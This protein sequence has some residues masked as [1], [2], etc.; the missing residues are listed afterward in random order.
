MQN[1][2]Q[3]DFEYTNDVSKQLEYEDAKLNQC[4]L[5]FKTKQG[6]YDNQKIINSKRFYETNVDD[7][8][9][10]GDSS[11]IINFI[12]SKKQ[13]ED[14]SDNE[15][16]KQNSN[17]GSITKKKHQLSQ[18]D[19]NLILNQSYF[20]DQPKKE[21]GQLEEHFRSTNQ[22]DQGVI[23]E[24]PSDR[25]T[26]QSVLS[27]QKCDVSDTLSRKKKQS[28][29]RADKKHLTTNVNKANNK[30]NNV[31]EYTKSTFKKKIKQDDIDRF[32]QRIKAFFYNKTYSGK[33][34]QLTEKVRLKIGDKSDY[35]DQD[36]RISMHV[37]IIDLIVAQVVWI[38]D[39]LI[40]MNTAMYHDNEF[41]EDRRIIM[42]TFLKEYFFFEVLPIIFENLHSSNIYVSILFHLPLLLKMKG[43][44]IMLD[45]LEFYILQMLDNHSIF[46]LFKL[47]MKMLLFGHILACLKYVVVQLEL[48]YQEQKIWSQ[49]EV[50]YSSQDQITNYLQCMYW[51]FTVMLNVQQPTPSTNLELVFTTFCMILSSIAFGY[52][53]SAIASI[54][55]KLNKNTEDFNKD[56]NILNQYMKRKK[57]EISLKRRANINLK[58]YYQQQLRTNIVEEKAT[59]QKVNSRMLKELLVSSNQKILKYC[60]FLTNLFSESTL[61]QICMS[62][63][64]VYYTPQETIV[65]SELKQSEHY[66]YIIIDGKVKVCEN[67]DRLAQP[68]NQQ[69]YFITQQRLLDK[70]MELQRIKK[71]NQ[72]DNSFQG[73]IYQK[74][75]YFGLLGL[76]LDTQL[77]QKAQSLEYTTIL[78]LSRKE[79]DRIIM[80]NQK[81]REMFMELKDRIL[82]NKDF[83]QLQ[84][85]CQFCNSRQHINQQCIL[86][87]FDRSN[88][89]LHSKNNFSQSQARGNLNQKRKQKYFH[90]LLDQRQIEDNLFELKSNYGMQSTNRIEFTQ[91]EI[92]DE[93]QENSQDQ[94]NLEQNEELFGS[95]EELKILEKSFEENNELDQKQ[96]ESISLDNPNTVSSN[97]KK[98]QSRTSQREKLKQQIKDNLFSKQINYDDSLKIS[99]FN[100]L[101][102]DEAQ[103]T[104]TQQTNQ[105]TTELQ[106]QSAQSLYNLKQNDIS[107]SINQQIQNNQQLSNRVRVKSQLSA[108]DEDTFIIDQIEDDYISKKSIQQMPSYIQHRSYDVYFQDVIHLQQQ[109]LQQQQQHEKTS[110]QNSLFNIQRIPTIDTGPNK[111]QIN[112]SQNHTPSSKQ[113]Y[114]GSNKMIEKQSTL[115]SN[116]QK[117]KNSLKN[118]SSINCQSTSLQPTISVRDLR[119]GNSKKEQIH[120]QLSKM[121]TKISQKSGSIPYKVEQDLKKTTKTNIQNSEI[122]FQDFMESD[123]H[124]RHQNS[125]HLNQ[126]KIIYWY[127]D[128]IQIFQY[129]FYNNNYPQQ[130]KKY[131]D[132]QEKQ[133]QKAKNFARQ[134]SFV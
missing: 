64:E 134:K 72:V 75:D 116:L 104:Y 103:Q 91:Q 97:M 17:H 95:L 21:S 56:L 45:N 68:I 90:S 9:Q 109:Q 79:L 33:T 22:K 92:M 43:I 73:E 48:N 108:V 24:R 121:M 124:H 11:Y 71:T 44:M 117:K 19:Q 26:L 111:R 18:Y 129:Y 29:Q 23:V 81:D 59:L 99:S 30:Q 132:Y 123:K 50:L 62:V 31:Q 84:V 38:A 60:P 125:K 118:S 119:N 16:L 74:G 89:I 61:Q 67:Y 28:G 65:D 57:I 27:N 114:F 96:Y 49:S 77:I 66:L 101:R 82:Y 40:Q 13:S 53:L 42:K 7:N 25:L 130:I 54:L 58:K 47:I 107:I 6:Q 100:E 98:F 106:R 113:K 83:N 85:H 15:A 102:L 37:K 35:V 126:D 4:T 86:L 87:H 69:N 20:S 122:D 133:D 51:A 5:D 88:Q 2:N 105:L 131:T 127:F 110:S 112:Q 36:H 34:K 55:S 63:E 70:L 80:L 128:K 93:S 120:S 14:Y 41:T 94:S 78:R 52:I 39:M 115:S 12:N 32:Y 8:K 10:D 46:Q 76:I 1:Q 3:A